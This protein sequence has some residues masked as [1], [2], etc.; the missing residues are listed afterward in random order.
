MDD[1][2]IQQRTSSRR[3][4]L[5][6]AAAGVGVVLSGGIVVSGAAAAGTHPGDSGNEPGNGASDPEVA[7]LGSAQSVRGAMV[8][9]GVEG[10]RP[11]GMRAVLT[12]AHVHTL[13]ELVTRAQI[14]RELPPQLQFRLRYFVEHDSTD[15][16]LQGANDEVYLSAIG[17]DSGD[18]VLGADGKPTARPI[19]VP[20]IG[21][22]SEN[23]VRDSWRTNP[24]VLMSFDLRR[25]AS[26][27]RSFVVTLLIV[28]HDDGDIAKAFRELE[29]KVGKTI[30]SA[31]EAAA[32]AGAGAIV[33]AT[34]GTVIPGVGTAVG[35]AVG[36]LVG[37]AYDEII[38]VINNGL[39]DDVF[40]PRPIEIVIA[41]PG[42]VRQ[43]PGIGKPQ[44][45]DVAEMGAHYS[46][47]YDWFLTG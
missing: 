7:L 11:H 9:L 18:V 26:W 42:Q 25:P 31:I 35:A 27:S 4:L 16:L 43:H 22:V 47:E 38:P 13:R 33:G 24:Y 30:K 21:D 5:R 41:D 15:D 14:A 36:A 32:V 37:V 28:E 20:S 8:Q 34:I 19:T 45:L 17:S 40:T 12:Q 46:I 29:E 44:V 10:L 1:S 3:A 39:A 2:S 23:S 6:A